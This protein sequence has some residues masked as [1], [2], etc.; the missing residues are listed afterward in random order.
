MDVSSD[1]CSSDLPYPNEVEGLE[2]PTHERRAPWV[3]ER[4]VPALPQ[5]SEV[6]VRETCTS[7]CRYRG[8]AGAP[9]SGWSRPARRSRRSALGRDRL[10]RNGRSR[11]SALLR[12][13]KPLIPIETE[14][15]HR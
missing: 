8:W 9:A 10:S 6:V 1:G 4:L 3:W 14:R 5:L 15:K 13:S 12:A 2:N 7:G 11:P